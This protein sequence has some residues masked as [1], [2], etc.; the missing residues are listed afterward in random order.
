MGFDI[1]LKMCQW[2]SSATGFKICH[3]QCGEVSPGACPN[4]NKHP[5]LILACSQPKK[6]RDLEDFYLQ[7]RWESLDQVEL[8]SPNKKI[9]EIFWPVLS[10]YCHGNVSLFNAVQG[11]PLPILL[12]P[13]G[14]IEGRVFFWRCLCLSESFRWHMWQNMSWRSNHLVLDDV[15]RVSW[16]RFCHDT[17]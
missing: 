6:N 2:A 11:T 8:D 3:L 10:C 12:D 13:S 1:W 15:I 5:H 9:L 17:R 16:Y 4:S 7:K 14:R